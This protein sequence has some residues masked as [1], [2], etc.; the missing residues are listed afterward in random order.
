MTELVV[1]FGADG[2]N[3]VGIYTPAANSGLA[4][5]RPTILFWNVGVSHRVGPQRLYCDLA[6]I[7]SALDFNVL[8][9]D[10]GGLG[11]SIAASSGKS[12]HEQ[13]INDIGTAMDYLSASYNQT[14]FV[15][16]GFCSGAATAHPVAVVDRRV[17]GLVMIDGY[18]YTTWQHGIR[19]FYRR[20]LSPA[21]IWSRM[22]RYLQTMFKP[23]VIVPGFFLDFPERGVVEQQIVG[24]ATRGVN[25]LFLYTG[26]VQVYFNHVRQ[27]WEMF[28]VV[29]KYAE[30]IT[31]KYFAG[32]NHMFMYKE[33]RIELLHCLQHWLLDRFAMC[34]AVGDKSESTREI[35]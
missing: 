20:L 7:F 15:L 16:I 32:C 8:R 9:F 35:I 4:A 18:G 31:V 10:L 29:R 13:E 28:P 30:M 22:I 24:L 1:D 2:A 6:R 21:N 5:R 26:G 11:D 23:E 3:L 33:N 27:F 12:R 14:K 17:V 34:A 19:H 25:I